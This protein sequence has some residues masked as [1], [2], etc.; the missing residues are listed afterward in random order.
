MIAGTL[1]NVLIFINHTEI[2]KATLVIFLI[3]AI[4]QIRYMILTDQ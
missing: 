2:A 4:I 1:Q 3:L